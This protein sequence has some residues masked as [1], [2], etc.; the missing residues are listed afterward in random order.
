MLPCIFCSAMMYVQNQG[1]PRSGRRLTTL[2]FSVRTGGGRETK[3]TT[4]EHQE[5]SYLQG[6]IPQDLK[7]MITRA[8]SSHSFSPLLLCVLPVYYT[9][10]HGS[11]RKSSRYLKFTRWTPPPHNNKKIAWSTHRIPSTACKS[12]TSGMLISHALPA[13]IVHVA[14]VQLAAYKIHTKLLDCLFHSGYSRSLCNRV[15]HSS[16][17]VLVH[18]AVC[19]LH[20]PSP[21]SVLPHCHGEK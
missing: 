9:V 5:S 1:L 18:M 4:T 7:T 19:L 12:F 14:F 16:C 15:F 2:G 17:I 3:R 10:V 21:A 13:T 20:S 8:T 6:H 11:Q